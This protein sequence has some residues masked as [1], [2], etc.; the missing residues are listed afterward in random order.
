MKKHSQLFSLLTYSIFLL[1]IVKSNADP[2]IDEIMGS[3][4]KGEIP[5]SETLPITVDFQISTS[6]FSKVNELQMSYELI[7]EERMSWQFSDFEYEG[8]A[9]VPSKYKSEFINL[10]SVLSDIWIPSTHIDNLIREQMKEQSLILY[11][12]GTFEYT[13][14]KFVLIS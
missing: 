11:P 8:N 10:N 6:P 7:L 3:Y 14:F 4:V 12:N 2:V 13:S 1:L 9:L 5:S